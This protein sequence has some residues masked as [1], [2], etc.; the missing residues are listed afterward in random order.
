[1]AAEAGLLE[2]GDA[3]RALALMDEIARATPLG[4][5]LGSGAAI[6][7]KVF[8][9]ERVPVVKGQAISAYDPRTIKG[10]G[11]TYATSPQGGDHT[12][13]LTVRANVNHLDPAGQVELS[14][15]AQVNVAGYDSLGACSFSGFGFA[16]APDALSQLLNARY[17][18]QVPQNILQILGRQT[19]TLEREFNRAAGF[20]SAHD[21]LPEWMTT[22]ALPPKNTVFDVKPEDLDRTLNFEG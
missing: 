14:R 9:I 3:E 6:T 5:V 20:T 1:V 11:V 17:G 19:I 4:R 22:E 16:T 13:G 15:T 10:T 8:G 12:A 21:R 18:W 2:F 7:G